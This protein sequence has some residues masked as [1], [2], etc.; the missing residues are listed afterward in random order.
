[1]LSTKL[2]Q[3]KRQLLKGKGSSGECEHTVHNI[4]KL[5]QKIKKAS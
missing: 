4:D 3:G 5:A 1:M 2:I